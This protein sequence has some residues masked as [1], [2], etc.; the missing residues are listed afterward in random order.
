MSAITYT[1]NNNEISLYD[2]FTSHRDA[3][4]SECTQKYNAG[5]TSFTI[6]VEG[7]ELQVKVET[8]NTWKLRGL[9][10]KVV[11]R[12]KTEVSFDDKTG[13]GNTRRGIEPAFN[14]AISGLI[15]QFLFTR[16]L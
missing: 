12:Y 6:T 7:K 1:S 16:S 4:Q 2:F 9:K 5:S 14:Q 3:I 15:D 13:K 8:N 11:T 10:S